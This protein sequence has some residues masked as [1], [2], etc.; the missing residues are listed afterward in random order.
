MAALGALKATTG[1]YA[2]AQ[3]QI[4]KVGPVI[5]NTPAPAS[6][7]TAG[8]VTY[9]ASDLIGGI[10]V[11]DPNGS[12]RTDVLPTAA[13]MV[14][15]MSESIP[16]RVGDT[17][18]FL[19]IN[20]SSGA[21]TITITAGTGGALDANQNSAA[22]AIQQNSSKEIALRLTSVTKGSEAYVFYC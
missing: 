8:A 9:L 3:D 21:N 18:F 20:G 13:L 15:A 7:N 22:A 12:P 5:Y 10:I 4:T 17:I 1:T 6:Y 19:I 14:T 11:R 16:A 2:E